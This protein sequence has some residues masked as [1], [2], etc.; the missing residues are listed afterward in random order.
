MTRVIEWSSP[1]KS[2]VKFGPLAE[3][4]GEWGY[5]PVGGPIQLTALKLPPNTGHGL[6]K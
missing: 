6:S 4:K 1:L 5:G 3:T 2:K